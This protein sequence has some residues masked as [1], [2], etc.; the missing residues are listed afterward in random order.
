M[1][2][3]KRI[4]ATVLSA[5]MM[6]AM[7]VTAF[8]AENGDEDRY[9]VINGI[10]GDAS[11]EVYCV[12][13]VNESKNTI[14][15]QDW[16]KDAGYALSQVNP[17]E[18]NDV[19]TV[20]MTG[21][22]VKNL[23]ASIDAGKADKLT[24]NDV[25]IVNG[26][27]KDTIHVVPSTFGIYLIK[28]VGSKAVYSPM[29]AYNFKNVNGK[30]VAYHQCI[31]AKRTNNDLTKEA[32][33]NFVYAGQEVEF[34][35]TK[36]I[37]LYARSFVIYDYATNLSDLTKSN[38]EV[39]IE[40]NKKADANFVKVGETENVGE[41]KYAIDG[42]SIVFDSE[43][44]EFINACSGKMITLKYTATVVGAEGYINKATYKTNDNA[45]STPVEV[46]GFEGGITLTKVEKGTDKK[47][48]GAEFTL[49]KV[50]PDG[51]KL[52]SDEALT[53]TKNDKGEY[54]FD[55]TSENTTLVTDENGLIVVKGLDE[56]EYQFTETKAP[57]GYS[58]NTEI[59]KVEV[60]A[61]K[62]NDQNTMAGLKVEDSTLIKLPFTG[63]MGTT[64]FTVLGVAVM[65][66]AAALFF[67]MKKS[68][69]K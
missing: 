19:D 62:N 65:A 8:A 3:F 20:E 37:P 59:E 34:T 68:S 13:K 56:G 52:V 6:L 25:K 45:E 67:G 69:A 31:D 33:D 47:L 21:T 26:E 40:G 44:D 63:G 61:A 4:I 46:K 30:Y 14:E 2:K 1:K 9:I 43:N 57:E 53:F 49:T 24:G 18:K 29:I 66:I 17:D 5:M 39:Y 55:A 15:V 7:S 35:I 51:A 28:A 23:E 50:G 41:I 42:T 16:A 64:L 58:I 60:K 11:V 22:Q 10:E 48:A 36:T 32:D 27:T 38:V 12:A 54:I